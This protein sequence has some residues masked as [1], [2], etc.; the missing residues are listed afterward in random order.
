M[1]HLRRAGFADWMPMDPL[2]GS[3]WWF[4]R[5]ILLGALFVGEKPTK[6]SGLFFTMEMMIRVD[7]Q[8]WGY[9]QESWMQ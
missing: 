5:Q 6:T 9:F 1:E 7:Q 3:R 4:L 2:D 8:S